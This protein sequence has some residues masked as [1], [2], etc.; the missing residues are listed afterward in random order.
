M[1]IPGFGT[2]LEQSLSVQSLHVLLLPAGSLWVPMLSFIC[3]V[4]SFVVLNKSAQLS[5][6]VHRYHLFLF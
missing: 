6:Q 1:P 5:S 3:L 4:R 2:C